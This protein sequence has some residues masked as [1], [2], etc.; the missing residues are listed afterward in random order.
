MNE[1][2]PLKKDIIFKTKI[3][4]I[5]NITIEHDYKI[6]DDLVEGSIDISGSY[7][8]TEASVIEEDFYYS[9]PF[10]IA[11][12]KNIKKDTINI[13]I[14]DFKYKI[15]SD[16]LS[17]SIDLNLDC[18]KEE[19][20]KNE[21]V[22]QIDIDLNNYEEENTILDNHNEIIDINDNHDDVVV[23]NSKIDD[24]FNNITNITNIIDSSNNYYTYKVYIVREGDTLETICT[25]YNIT[26]E[27]L[28]LYN[29]L[30]DLHIGDK[31]LIPYVNE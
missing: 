4:E 13:E 24:S 2:I 29:D 11:I 17:V 12:S 25:K 10:S 22:D 9:I 1:I 30:T 7:K 18:E 21:V 31:L 26:L 28:K 19:E 15:Y 6:N 23:E 5:T 3:G 8:M 27:D 14:E 20:I 16:V